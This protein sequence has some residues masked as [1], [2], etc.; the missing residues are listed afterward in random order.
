MEYL[1]KSGQADPDVVDLLEA[2]E[3]GQQGKGM[4]YK[5]LNVQPK[6]HHITGNVDYLQLKLGGKP[7]GLCANVRRALLNENTTGYYFRYFTF[8]K[9]F[10]VAKVS[11]D[12][13]S[14]NSAIRK[15][16]NQYLDKQNNGITYAFVDLTN[17]RSRT[18][19]EAFDFKE[20]GQ[21]TTL[22]FSRLFPKASNR[23]EETDLQEVE[24][25]LCK[26]YKDYSLFTLDNIR[27]KATSYYTLREG[28]EILAGIAATEERW[29]IIE[30]PDFL[31]SL[32]LKIK[33]PFLNRLFSADYRFLTIEGIYQK[34][35]C[36]KELTE[37][38]EGV[39]SA[40][41]HHVA[42]MW[43]DVKSPLYRKLK[44][45]S[46]G[47]LSKFNSEV[48]ASVIVRNYGKSLKNIYISGF[49]LT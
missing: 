31:G 16:I 40:T 26:H 25:L 45:L 13:R 49:D 6:I 11:A 37:L 2:N 30:M 41:N 29:K 7:V 12:K 15:E 18:I 22:I 36:E 19:C 5:H 24:E 35:G 32:L 14:K 9:G 46:L 42:M 39:L 47:L 43:A 28:D 10:R 38:L 44:L 20:V 21:F 3:I 34:E 8:L 48:R 33:L 1:F 4:V 23:I 17:E 27:Y